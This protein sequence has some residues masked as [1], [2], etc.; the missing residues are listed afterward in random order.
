MARTNHGRKPP[1]PST[2]ADPPAGTAPR[3]EVPSTLALLADERDFAAMRHYAT[4][5]FSDHETYLRAMEALLR[6]LAAEGVHTAVALFDPDDYAEFCADTGLEPDSPLSRTR[7]TAECAAAGPTLPYEGQP[8]DRL[9]AALVETADRH[10]TLECAA[11]LLA[12]LGRCADCGAD[13]GRAAYHR[14]V[15]A[16]TRLLEAVGPGGHHLVCSVPVNGTPLIAVLQARTGPGGTARLLEAEALVFCTVL[17]IGIATDTGGGLVLRTDRPPAG[18]DTVRGW[19]LNDGWPR[20]LTA[21]EV[22]SA[23]CTDADTGDPVPP[24]PGVEHLPGIALPAPEDDHGPHGRHRPE[25][26][27]SPEEKRE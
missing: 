7:Y 26:K 4:F 1:T 24:E 22:F 3:G 8:I 5:T 6:S 13:L 11:T 18:P 27:R 14:A 17:A 19:V 21:A 9:A 20:P 23:Y 25:E 12:G 2:P 16:V 15:H 10:A